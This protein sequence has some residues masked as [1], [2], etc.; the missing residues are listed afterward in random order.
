MVNKPNA[1]EAVARISHVRPLCGLPQKVAPAHTALVVIDMQNDFIADGCLMGQEGW[2]L[3]AVQEMAA[4]L[5][6][7]IA[8]ARK[9]GITV[10]FVRNVYS[11]ERNFYLSDV[12]LE[13]AARKRPGGYTYIPGC[14]ADSRGGDFYGDVRPKL[15]DPVVIK[16]RYNGFHNTDLDIILR[17]HGI[18]TLVFTGVSTNCCVETTARDAFMRDYYVIVVDDATA[19]YAQAFHEMALK[20]IDSLFGEI[21]TIAALSAIWEGYSA[22]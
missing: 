4:R 1:Y 16:H 2:N 6:A 8:A 13:Q 5:P 11:T 21:T 19:S 15:G 18:R 20:N 10:I 3:S 22:G 9:S 17:A 14:E 7:L 12:W